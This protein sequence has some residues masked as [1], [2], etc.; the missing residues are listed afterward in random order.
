[1]KFIHYTDMI[2]VNLDLVETFYLQNTEDKGKTVYK[3][4]FQ[5]KGGNINT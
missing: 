3:I 2:T 4:V 5:F 1:M